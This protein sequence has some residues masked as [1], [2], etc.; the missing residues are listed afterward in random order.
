MIS[1]FIVIHFNLEQFVER[2]L[3]GTRCSFQFGVRLRTSSGAP[4]RRESR[5]YFYEVVTSNGGELSE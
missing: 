1:A 5:D 2:N 3:H 4:Y